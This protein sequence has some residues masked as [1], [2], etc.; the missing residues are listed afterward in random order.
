M[1]CSK[2]NVSIRHVDIGTR[3]LEIPLTRIESVSA[4]SVSPV[5]TIVCWPVA[6]RVV[7]R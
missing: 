4:A 2:K 3:A 7:G 1:H 6:P 5:T